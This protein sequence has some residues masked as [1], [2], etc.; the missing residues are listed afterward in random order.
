MPISGRSDCASSQALFLGAQQSHHRGW[1][2]CRLRE[3]CGR[4]LSAAPILGRSCGELQQVPSWPE[5]PEGKSTGMYSSPA[6]RARKAAGCKRPAAGV[7]VLH[8]SQG[9]MISRAACENCFPGAHH[10]CMQ[11]P[12]GCRPRQVCNRRPLLRLPQGAVA[13]RRATVIVT[14]QHQVRCFSVHHQMYA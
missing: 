8:S 1:R 5:V 13:A 7:S 11:G 14:S 2:G 9:A 6:R 12:E 3:A 10:S 4:R